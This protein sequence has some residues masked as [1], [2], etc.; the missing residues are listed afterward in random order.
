V[1]NGAAQAPATGIYKDKASG[2]TYQ[3]DYRAKTATL[4]SVMTPEMLSKVPPIEEARKRAVAEEVI[5][6]ISSLCFPALDGKTGATIGL[7]CR[8]FEYDLEMKGEAVLTVGGERTK[9]L[10]ELY[11]VQLGVAP[12]EPVEIPTDFRVVE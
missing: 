8:S 6:G 10:W 5:Q 7:A 11:D 4:R 9:S 1:I 12:T 2:K 3:L